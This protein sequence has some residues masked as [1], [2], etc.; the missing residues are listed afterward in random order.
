MPQL[1]ESVPGQDGSLIFK[2]NG[3]FALKNYNVEIVNGNRLKV[4]SATNELFSL[5]EADVSEVEINGMLYSSAEAA[6]IAL[7]ALVYSSEKPQIL[8]EEDKRNILAGIVGDAELNTLPSSTKFERWYASLIGT[9]TNFI[10]SNGLPIKVIKEELEEFEV[11]ISVT[12][13]IAKKVYISK[14]TEQAEKIFD[15]TNDVRSS[16]MRATFNASDILF[17]EAVTQKAGFSEPI[18]FGFGTDSTETSNYNVVRVND[19]PIT[20]PGVLSKISQNSTGNNTD[21]QFCVVRPLGGTLFKT[22]KVFGASGFTPNVVSSVPITENVEVKIGDRLG[23]FV[24]N[25]DFKLN[26]TLGNSLNF[27]ASAMVEGAETGANVNSGLSWCYTFEIKQAKLTGDDAVRILSGLNTSSVNSKTYYLEDYGGAPLDPFNPD[28]SVDCTKALQDCIDDIF[29]DNNVVNAKLVLKGFYRLG[30]A[31]KTWPNGKKAQAMAPT[32][33][34]GP[35]M[36]IKNLALIGEYQPVWEEQT[37][38]RMP[39]SFAGS[40]FYSSIYNQSL[41]TRNWVLSFGSG[42]N[43]DVFGEF[44]NI[45]LFL[46]NFAVI[47]RS[48]DE[49]GQPVVNT[50]SGIDVEHNSNLQF[51]RI[52]VRT[53][54]PAKDALM[55]SVNS[56]GIIMPKWNNHASIDGTYLRCNG[57]GTGMVA[58][59]HLEL[60]KYIGL[61]NIIGMRC[62]KFYPVNIGQGILEMNKYPIVMGDGAY[63][64]I[65]VYQ[66]ERST[67]TAEW[68]YSTKDIVQEPGANNQPGAS[69][70]TINRLV[71][72]K[73]GG[74][75][76]TGSW[77]NGVRVKVINDEHSLSYNPLNMW[78]DLPPNPVNGL[79]GYHQGI[80]KIYIDGWK[81]AL[82]GN[83][84]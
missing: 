65:D 59:E 38:V 83:P 31:L 77:D 48:H 79:E 71:V 2:F 3:Q 72:H 37:L 84:V 74:E 67:D 27:P 80:R 78:Q 61:G 34:F 11:I 62:D 82:T 22:V 7:Q 12:N 46:D 32:I 43:S 44:N 50:M 51:G 1:F 49:N 10:D 5:L 69:S 8:S 24:N 39:V 81:N 4:T 57:F 56:F 66:T 70:V 9:Y 21:V 18:L 55:P 28:N 30:G 36:V 13:G 6:Q 20:V 53:S 41:N 52:L 54:V 40:G 19:I 76:G 75:K 35:G 63:L 15:K 68:W 23:F 14:Q 16:T 17:D 33:D 58:A 25:K 73:A 45:N 47:T 42:R 60:R 26:T 29:N 64:N